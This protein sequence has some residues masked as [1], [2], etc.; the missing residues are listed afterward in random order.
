MY[1][2]RSQPKKNRNQTVRTMTC[3]IKLFPTQPT[4]CWKEHNAQLA[5]VGSDRVRRLICWRCKAQYHYNCMQH[6]IERTQ[7][8]QRWQFTKCSQ[9]P[10]ADG[11]DKKQ[12]SVL[13]KKSSCLHIPQLCILQW[14]ANSIHAKTTTSGRSP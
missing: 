14:N 5:Q 6:P 9:K 3:Q 4:D 12:Q 2:Q 1:Y 7:M 13:D 8:I 10:V 11:D